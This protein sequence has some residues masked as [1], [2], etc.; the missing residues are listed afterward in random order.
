MSVSYLQARFQWTPE[1][2][3]SIHWGAHGTALRGQRVSHVHFTKLVYDLL[4]TN[5]LLHRY[6]S[7]SH[8]SKCPCCDL[9]I[10]ETRDH[11]LQCSATDAWRE[12]FLTS[13]RKRCGELNTSPRLQEYLFVTIRTWLTD[14]EVR[15]VDGFPRAFQQLTESQSAIGWRHVFSGRFSVQWA[16]AQSCHLEQEDVDQPTTAGVQWLV[17]IITTIWQQW[18]ELWKHRN[19]IVHGKDEAAQHQIQKRILEN[20]IHKVYEL[21]HRVEP[22]LKHVFTSTAQYH[23]DKGNTHMTNWLAVHELA[24]IESEAK[25][26]SRAIQGTR[27]ILSYFGGGGG[28]V[29]SLKKSHLQVFSQT[30]M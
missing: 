24:A 17:E 20:R 29:P 11:L 13:L 3:A 28:T 10:D 22:S 30:C 5:K 6:N 8:T 12:S 18:R 14:G 21:K 23:I 1:V 19:N 9:Q 26:T 25:A 27:S 16:I 7:S 4:P 15:A 2:F